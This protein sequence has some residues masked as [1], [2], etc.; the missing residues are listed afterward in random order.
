MAG[1]AGKNLLLKVESPT[2]AGTFITLGGLRSKSISINNEE[3]DGTNHGSNE[4]KESLD[5]AGIRSMSISGSGIFDNSTVLK[6]AIKD[7]IAGK[8]RKY[9]IIDTDTD[10]KFEGTFK[11]TS[12]EFAGEYNAEQTYS[13]SLNSSGAVEFDDAA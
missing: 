11:I 1:K 2:V 5:E 13:L 12:C 4:W 8:H 7:V 9:Q 6:Q 3:I 10:M